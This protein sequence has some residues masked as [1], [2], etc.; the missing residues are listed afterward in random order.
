MKQSKVISTIA[1]SLFAFTM[2]NCSAKHETRNSRD[3]APN[4]TQSKAEIDCKINTNNPVGEFYRQVE[5]LKDLR[6]NNVTGGKIEEHVIVEVVNSFT[7]TDE[8]N[9]LLNGE[10]FRSEREKALFIQNFL[11][12]GLIRTYALDEEI[13]SIPERNCVARSLYQ[14]DVIRVNDQT[15]RI[16]N[17]DLSW[18]TAVGSKVIESKLTEKNESLVALINTVD[19][20]V[21]IT[22]DPTR[23]QEI[24]KRNKSLQTFEAHRVISKDATAS[25]QI[26]REFV[27]V[28]KSEL[29]NIKTNIADNSLILLASLLSGQK[30]KSTPK[31]ETADTNTKSLL[32]LSPR[33]IGEKIMELGSDLFEAGDQAVF[34][35]KG[36]TGLGSRTESLADLSEMDKLIDNEAK[37]QIKSVEALNMEKTQPETPA[38]EP[39]AEEPKAEKSE[40]VKEKT[41]DKKESEKQKEEKSTDSIE[42]SEDQKVSA[43]ESNTETA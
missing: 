24:D 14:G 37:K 26:N 33:M 10:E 41:E 34:K 29:S 23:L 11:P 17:A 36:V 4:N 2:I 1:I 18:I 42:K 32:D 35:L 15:M 13:V 39:K 22:M 6:N 28:P 40:T 5:N 27:I 25:I 8:G 30:D 16:D 21:S 31:K 43:D 3:L 19:S 9:I 7:V 20:T 38:E 12:N